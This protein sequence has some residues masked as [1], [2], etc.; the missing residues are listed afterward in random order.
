VFKNYF[1]SDISALSTKTQE[2][3]ES[4]AHN[5][6]N[7]LYRNILTQRTAHCFAP[8]LPNCVYNT[9]TV[10]QGLPVPATGVTPPQA[11]LTLRSPSEKG[12]AHAASLHPVFVA[13]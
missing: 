12:Y 1:V 13:G 7:D 3:N 5:Y 8:I 4:K 6:L 11:R 2:N 9:L 10:V